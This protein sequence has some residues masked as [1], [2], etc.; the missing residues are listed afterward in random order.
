MKCN[1]EWLSAYLDGALADDKRAKLEEHLKTCEVCT[2]KLEEFA[3]AEQA[4]QKISVPRLSEAY[5][6]N[7]ASRV[8]NKLTIR[9]KQKT[10]P[11][12]LEALKSF[13]Q[14][15]TGKLAIAGSVA[16]LILL[17][18]ISLDQWKKQTFR[19]PVFEAEKP[20]AEG[21]IDSV[22][23]SAKDESA[24][25]ANEAVKDTKVGLVEEKRA[26]LSAPERETA[27]L[28]QKP[29]ENVPAASAPLARAL[30]APEEQKSE[31]N[32]KLQIRNVGNLSKIQAGVSEKD[33]QIHIRGGRRPIEGDTLTDT[34]GRKTDVQ[35]ETDTSKNEMLRKEVQRVTDLLKIQVGVTANKEPNWRR[36][37]TSDSNDTSTALQGAKTKQSSYSKDT[38]TKPAA[39]KNS[40]E[41]F[42]L[43]KGG[44]DAQYGNKAMP[45][46]DTA[47]L[48]SD[49]RQIIAEKEKQLKGKLS[50]TET[51]SLY[52]YLAQY[53]VQLYRFSLEQNDWKKADQ[54]LADFLKANLSE[55]NRRWLVA[56][57]VELKNLKK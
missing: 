10:S 26:D 8:Q 47:Q 27:I 4:A 46:I 6:E 38:V 12:W 33:G 5:W 57:Q 53:Y 54:R 18:F 32:E 13:F 15:T 20:L 40:T 55:S 21:N 43:I 14:P 9:E 35:K 31:G 36:R 52:I 45:A 1:W 7:F 3:R 16:V 37:V 48:V 30:A 41:Q 39:P 19:P 56:I 50:K 42:S 28:S 17:T 44:F 34:T 11:G 29:T 51:E 23:T 49:I 24:F 25:R 22:L 2:A